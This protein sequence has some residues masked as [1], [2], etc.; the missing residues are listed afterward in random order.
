M[1]VEEK[2]E[3]RSLVPQAAQGVGLT[4]AVMACVMYLV[5]VVG[6]SLTMWSQ[7][8]VVS[9]GPDA[10]G[11]SSGGQ[12][13]LAGVVAGAVI[14]LVLA[15]LGL[16]GVAMTRGSWFRVRFTGGHQ[17][18]GRRCRWS[19]LGPAMA[20]LPPAGIA[21]AIA[22]YYLRQALP[23]LGG[24]DAG[25][26]LA[27]L[28]GSWSGTAVLTAVLTG[29]GASVSEEV[30]A[31]AVPIWAGGKLGR[32]LGVSARQRQVGLWVIG[33]LLVGVRMA[34]HLYQGGGAMEHLPW[35]IATVVLYV[36]TRKLVPIVLSHFATDVTLILG[37]AAHPSTLTS[38]LAV[39]A[40]PTL[41]LAAVLLLWERRR[42]AARERLPTLA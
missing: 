18:S 25:Y 6:V 33:A 21:G 42:A 28:T 11:E 32:Q 39:Y 31:L 15:V 19:G 35:A 9:S 7:L 16:V 12:E 26:A 27:G 36:H 29:A 24:P 5:L 22:W 13:D 2:V 17:P 14:Y 1:Q 37:H 30:L 38:T 41:V 8:Q 23:G 3:R 20:I 4:L 40:G 10:S 34:Y